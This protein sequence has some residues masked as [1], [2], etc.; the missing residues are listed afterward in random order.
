MPRKTKPR[1]GR[2]ATTRSK[3]TPP[4]SYRVSAEQRLELQQ[5]ADRL[6]LD[7][8]NEAAKRRAFPTG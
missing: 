6:G 1:R 5:E 3:S 4:V 7:G 8:P 2:P